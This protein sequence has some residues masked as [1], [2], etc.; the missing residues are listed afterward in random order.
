MRSEAGL[1]APGPTPPRLPVSPKR[2]S[3]DESSFDAGVDSPRGA[4]AEG[5]ES[6]EGFASQPG[7]ADEKK[8]AS[9]VPVINEPKKK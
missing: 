2:E 1:L 7:S 3:V 8:S 4:R 9:L 6:W 5:A